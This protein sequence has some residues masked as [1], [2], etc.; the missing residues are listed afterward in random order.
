MN[1]VSMKQVESWKSQAGPALQ[2]R[3]LS[4]WL[5]KI[6]EISDGATL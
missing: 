2:P 5:I 6:S 3:Q 1:Q 4:E